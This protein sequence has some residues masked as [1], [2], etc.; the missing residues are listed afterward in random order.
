[1]KISITSLLSKVSVKIIPLT[2]RQIPKPPLGAAASLCFVS[3][4]YASI[5]HNKV[6][7]L[8]L[9]YIT[10]GTFHQLFLV[11]TFLSLEKMFSLTEL[12]KEWS[13]QTQNKE[14][15]ILLTPAP[16][17]HFSNLLSRLVRLPIT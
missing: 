5:G 4:L 10:V 6:L 2:V 16:E 13:L 3:Y 15:F 7:S 14:E 12:M 11:T 1:M 17:L 9:Y 8:Q